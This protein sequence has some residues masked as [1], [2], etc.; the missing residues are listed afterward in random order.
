LPS[1][2][3]IIYQIKDEVALLGERDVRREN[4]A[5]V[6][7]RAD[8]P[9]GK[10]RALK[11]LPNLEVPVSLKKSEEAYLGLLMDALYYEVVSHV[12]VSIKYVAGCL[13]Y[14]DDVDKLLGSVAML[15]K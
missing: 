15:G 11:V 3:V 2:L 10:P 7:L 9:N 6:T 4:H 1:K 12:L 13:S 8:N 5:I 14:K